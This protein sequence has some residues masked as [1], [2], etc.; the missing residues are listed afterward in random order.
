MQ[1]AEIEAIVAAILTGDQQRSADVS[2]KAVV[3]R[4]R[5]ILMEIRETG[6]IDKDLSESQGNVGNAGGSG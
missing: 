2:A 1:R 3:A 5:E 4:F 6:G